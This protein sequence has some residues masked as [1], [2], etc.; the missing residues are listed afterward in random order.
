M[1]KKQK[2]IE[3]LQEQLAAE[4]IDTGLIEYHEKLLEIEPNDNNKF[5]LATLYIKAREERYINAGFILLKELIH[6][7]NSTS[8]DAFE[9]NSR[10]YKRDCMYLMALGYY[11]LED[12]PAARRWIEKL[13]EFDPGNYQAIRLLDLVDL[14]IKEEGAKGL[15]IAGGAAA[16]TVGA[17]AAIGGVLMF[18]L[19][20]K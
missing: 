15:M 7:Q 9:T 12:Y 10:H 1:A 13:L 2:D 19:M 6:Q 11:H 16:V 18:A 5:A 3:N 14:R 20:K 8:F 17:L 4:V